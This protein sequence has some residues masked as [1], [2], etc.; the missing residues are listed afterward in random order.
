MP[1][2]NASILIFSIFPTAL[3]EIR[4]KNEAKKR[5]AELK[6]EAE[7]KG[8]PTD[9]IHVEPGTVDWLYGDQNKAQEQG[10]GIMC[11]TV[12]LLSVHLSV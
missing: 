5:E 7:A 2:N 4:N 1:L 11:Y 9:N 6:A 10:E 3:L 8:L 12:I